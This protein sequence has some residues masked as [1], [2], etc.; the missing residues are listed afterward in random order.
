MNRIS[1]RFRAAGM[2]LSLLLCMT[3]FTG[4]GASAAPDTSPVKDGETLCFAFSPADY[5]DGYNQL[6]R[7]EREGGDMRPFS[8]WVGLTD[9]AADS[10]FSGWNV[11]RFKQDE[12]CWS[13]PAV[14]IYPSEDGKHVRAI[15]FDL[16]DHAYTEYSFVEFRR[17]CLRSMR[18]L[19]GISGD[20]A[21][22]LFEALYL[23]AAEGKG[24]YPDS[25][26][27]VPR[28]IYCG[29]NVGFYPYFRNGCMLRIC[30]VPVT[31]EY[32]SQLEANGADIYDL[33]LNPFGNY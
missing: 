14:M 13:D 18:L 32:L 21:D 19:T 20:A 22:A 33:D 2:V 25:S 16:D 27:A 8:A 30:A 17:S 9:E 4:C 12:N 24:W 15:T 10:P 3:I 6:C 26:G 31:D 7:K 5:I 29:G 11:R 23:Q 28:V 1:D